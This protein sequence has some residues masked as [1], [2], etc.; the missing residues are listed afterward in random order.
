MVPVREKNIIQVEVTNACVNECTNCSRFVG[1]YRQPYFMALTQVEKSIDSLSDFCGG[2]GIMGGEPLLHPEFTEIC[3]FMGEK[4]P[5]DRRY[6]YTT[7]YNWDKYR[8]LVKKTFGRHVFFNNH[9]D[10]TQKHHPMLL[11]IQDVIADSGKVKRLL[12]DCWVER[13]WSASINPK[14]CFFCEIAAAMD[15]LF[16]GP[17]G[18][19]IERDWWRKDPEDFIDQRERYCYRCGACVPFKAV[20]LEDSKDVVSIG[21]YREL[22][23]V[24]SPKL[25]KTGLPV[26]YEILSEQ[27]IEAFAESWQPWNHLGFKDKRGQGMD[28][29]NMYGKLYGFKLRLEDMV[30]S[31]GWV[32]KAGISIYRWLWHLKRA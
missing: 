6:L 24:D 30:A 8:R 7:G 1:H 18:H 4:V 17:G 32:R 14:G 29:Y 16:D 13:R 28:K 26:I 9:S 21:N 2:I 19:P 11:G 12:E 15:V 5:P 10:T 22:V 31:I 23:A 27:Q 3:N 25:R 20:R